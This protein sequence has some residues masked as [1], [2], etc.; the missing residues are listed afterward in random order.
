MIS[1]LAVLMLRGPQTPGE[2]KQRTER[3]HRFEGLDEVEAVLE[4]LAERELAER[5]PRRPGQK[6][7]RYTQ[8]LGEEAS[9]APV[10]SYDAP[11]PG[12]DDDDRLTAL[13]KPR[14]AAPEQVAASVRSSLRSAELE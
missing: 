8:L 14:D 1:L 11:E 9:P 3:L 2:L 4:R 6:E 12:E 10:P 5:L 7:E 13:G